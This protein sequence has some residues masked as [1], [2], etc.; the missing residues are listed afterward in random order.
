MFEQL[1]QGPLPTSSPTSSASSAA[2]SA[3]DEEVSAM[4]AQYFCRM[5]DTIG[6]PRSVALIYHV[7]F[8]ADQPLS[9]ADIVDRSG[10]SKASA[11]TGLKFLERLHGLE[12]VVLP[13]DRRTFYKAERSLRRLVTG[14]VT[15][16]LQ[17]GLDGGQRLLDQAALSSARTSVSPLLAERL[18]S[19]RHWHQLTS[20]LLPTVTALDSYELPF[21]KP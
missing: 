3:A 8:L 21:D 1:E 9:F 2:L 17:P 10:L 6:L 15:Q 11:S 20:Q 7:L 14:F 16:N 4:L 12:T 19:L 13:E 5:A 18:A